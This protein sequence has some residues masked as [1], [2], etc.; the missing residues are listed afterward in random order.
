MKPFV[1]IRAS[2]AAVALAVASS[3]TAGAAGIGAARADGHST[4]IAAVA[5]D[6]ARKTELLRLLRQ[7]CGSCHGMR[8]TG[9]LGPPLTP[10]ALRDKPAD[11]LTA[12]IVA[13]RAGTAMPPWRPFLSEA[14]AAWLV[15]RLQQGDAHA[16]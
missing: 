16:R 8:L 12:T 1:A 13:G 7:D 10:Q 11:S 14:E 5:P 3:V 2:L 4:A 6:A 15:E 9:G